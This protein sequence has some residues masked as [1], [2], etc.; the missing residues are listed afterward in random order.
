MTRSSVTGKFYY[1]AYGSN[2]WDER[3]KEPGS[4]NTRRRCP[5]ARKIKP[6]T[7]SQHLLKGWKLNFSKK[8]QDR[9]GKGNIVEIRR[10][11]EKVY[12]VIFEILDSEKQE[13]DCAEL[14]YD[15]REMTILDERNSR[16]NCENVIVYYKEEP[17][18]SKI[19]YDWYKAYIVEGAKKHNLPFIRF[20]CR[21]HGKSFGNFEDFSISFGVPFAIIDCSPR[22]YALSTI[23]NKF[24][25]WWSVTRIAHP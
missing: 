3:L 2:L 8:S 11:G 12:G 13:L 16:K 22:T 15:Q 10:D 21:G 23:S 6:S 7:G 25:T 14:G 18:N 4:E 5:S 24:R 1:F 19:P 17:D 9:S 20:D